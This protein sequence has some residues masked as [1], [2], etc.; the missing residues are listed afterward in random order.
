MGEHSV[1]RSRVIPADPAAVF[2]VVSDPS[3]H[4]VIDG[5]GHVTGSRTAASQLKLGDK[6]TTSNKIGVPYLI[7][8][9]V[10]EFEQDK[11][12][13]WSHAGGWRWRFELEEVEGG[14]NVTESFDWST[15]KSRT[16]IEVLGWP[17]R[18]AG[19]LEKTLDR[20]EAY[21]AHRADL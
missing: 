10:K 18:N 8:N 16:Y 21:F 13:A 12:I 20:L 5:S 14:T 6:F 7:S 9:T 11:L 19:N 3:M 1:S 15:A 4:P 2:K 17:A